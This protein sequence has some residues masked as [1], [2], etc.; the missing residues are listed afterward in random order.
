MSSSTNL[1]KSNLDEKN[2]PAQKVISVVAL[3]LRRSLD[4]RFLLTRRGPGQS[5]AGEWEFPGGK[6]EAGETQVD[7]LKREIEEELG[8]SV[9]VDQLQFVA[10]NLHSYPT[11]QVHLFLWTIRL[12][13]IPKITLTEHD[14][15]QWCNPVEMQMIHLS[16]GDIPFIDCLTLI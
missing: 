15:V 7:A 11:K 10:E 8:F 14:A 12:Q 4:E 13:E 2:S 1:K 5:G 3:A 16:Q 9:Q 6:V